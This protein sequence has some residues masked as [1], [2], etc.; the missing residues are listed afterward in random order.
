[1]PHFWYCIVPC[2]ALLFLGRLF[3]FFGLPYVYR[4]RIS[5]QGAGV[6]VSEFLVLF[7][8]LSSVLLWPV[9]FCGLFLDPWSS[10]FSLC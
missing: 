10:T 9:V 2:A 6:S 5:F 4:D 7:S 1:M 3:T 8:V